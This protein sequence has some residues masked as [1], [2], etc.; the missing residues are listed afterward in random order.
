VDVADDPALFGA[1]VAELL[2]NDALRHQRSVLAIEQ[3][4]RHFTEAAAYAPL[5]AMLQGVR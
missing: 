3:Y 4:E 1:A 5:I 2:G